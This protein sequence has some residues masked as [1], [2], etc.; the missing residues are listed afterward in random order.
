MEVNQLL[1]STKLLSFSK[2][3]N[4]SKYPGYFS[5]T[6][7][8]YE[9]SMGLEVRR[10]G[11]QFWIHLELSELETVSQ[12]PSLSFSCFIWKKSLDAKTKDPSN[13]QVLSP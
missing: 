2:Q 12:P 5:N 10:P 8:K 13:I 11:L 1:A 9:K 6:F 3:A 4:A 7:E